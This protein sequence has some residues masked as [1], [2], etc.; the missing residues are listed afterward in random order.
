MLAWVAR[1]SFRQD[2]RRDTTRQLGDDTLRGYFWGVGLVSVGLARVHKY[3]GFE[4]DRPDDGLV[5]QSRACY[6]YSG[7]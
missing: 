5:V 6:N 4:T 2:G 7:G 1:R 3:M